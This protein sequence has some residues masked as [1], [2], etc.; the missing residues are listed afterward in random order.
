MTDGS[1]VDQ[2]LDDRWRGVEVAVLREDAGVGFGETIS[3]LG[4]ALAL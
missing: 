1:H 4:D 2:M 3:P